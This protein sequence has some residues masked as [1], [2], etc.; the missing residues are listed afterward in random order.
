VSAEAA[1]IL[2]GILVLVD[3]AIRVV[4]LIVIPRD[5][6]PTAAMAWLLAIFFIPFVGIV[7]FLLIGNVKLPKARQERQLAIN[8]MIADRSEGLEL[9]DDRAEWPAWFASVVEQNRRVGALPAMGRNAARLIDDYRAS[10]DAMAADIDTATRF[11]HVEF[12]I[13]AFDE[14]TKG[15]FAAME[16]AVQRGVIV[17]VLLDHVASRRVAGHD[18]TFAELDRIGAKWAFLLPVQPARGHY[19]RPDLRNH[20]KLVVV[21][22]RVAFTGSQN[23]IDRGYDSPKNQKRGLQ[24]QELVVRVTGPIVTAVNAVFLSDWYSETNELLGDEE[25]VPVAAVPADP[26]PDALVCQVVPSGPAFEGENNLRLFLSLVTSAQKQVIITSPYF[27]PDE[28]MMYAI[29]SARYRGL[30]VQLFVSEIGDQG[31]VWH[32]QRSYYGALL[33]A[34]VKIWM[35]PGPYI[36]HAKHLSIDDDVA[37]IGSSNMDIRSFNLNFEISL[38]VRG[39]SFV[40]EMREVEAGYRAIGRELTL[41]EWEKEPVSA[42]FLDGVARLTSA[43]Q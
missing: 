9:V 4:A 41:E 2:G 43:L 12:F 1:A 33:R 19:Q 7:L 13:V 8:R 22:G 11:V 20:R 37:V 25:N 15:F 24:W 30:D 6:K 31:S 10:I 36:L 17:R 38:L 18:E 29:T 23:L 5:R 26:S 34:G 27:V 42:T 32:A 39:A 3:F 28:A 40:A 14:T 16:R 35:Y 21:D